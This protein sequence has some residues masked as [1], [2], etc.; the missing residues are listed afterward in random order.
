MIWNHAEIICL[1]IY[2]G[3]GR[4]KPRNAHT[5]TPPAPFHYVIALYTI[6]LLKTTLN[7]YA[8]YSRQENKR[9][10][11]FLQSLSAVHQII[12]ESQHLLIPTHMKGFSF[13]DTSK[14]LIA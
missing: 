7:Q 6:L 2:E 9:Q 11:R 4:E 3:Y 14:G 13:Y 1:A 8:A 5:S 12:I 10:R